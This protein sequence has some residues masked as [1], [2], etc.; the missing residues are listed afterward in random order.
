MKGKAAAIAVTKPG[1]L[2]SIPTLDEVIV[3]KDSV[4]TFSPNGLLAPVVH[5]L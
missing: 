3:A 2:D 4:I 5:N 1:A